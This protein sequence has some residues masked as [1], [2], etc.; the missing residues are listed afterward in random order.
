LCDQPATHAER[1]PVIRRIK[2]QTYEVGLYF[3]DGEFRGL[4]QPGRHWILDPLRRVHVDVVSQRTPWL[5]HDKLDVIVKSGALGDR[6]R[7]LDLK[8]YERGLVWVDGRFSHI[9]PPGLYAYWTALRDV[10][11]EVVDARSVRF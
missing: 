1:C 5:F 4:L 8:D 3:R 10:R 6:A 11:I 7:V 2:I 9:L